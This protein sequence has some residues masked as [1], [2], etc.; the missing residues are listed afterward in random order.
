[1]NRIMFIAG[2]AL[3]S[4]S[5]SAEE[6]QIQNLLPT[7]SWMITCSDSPLQKHVDAVANEL[8]QL[9]L[10]TASEPLDHWRHGGQTL[11]AGDGSKIWISMIWLAPSPPIISVPTET[12]YD[13]SI[14]ATSKVSDD[15]IFQIGKLIEKS[16]QSSS[17]CKVN[18]AQAISR[19]QSDESIENFIAKSKIREQ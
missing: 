1:M 18:L 9:G 3:L 6:K 7:A 17:L 16:L 12:G 19:A 10:A 8:R 2:S 15:S 4:A 14:S 5:C 11:R 13:V